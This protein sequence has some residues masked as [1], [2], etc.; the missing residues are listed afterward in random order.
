M[1]N[2]NDQLENPV[3]GKNE[4]AFDDQRG[5]TTPEGGNDSLAAD[6]E[7]EDSS[8]VLDEADLEENNISD[9]EADNIEWGPEGKKGGKQ[10]ITNAADTGSQNKGTDDDNRTGSN[11]MRTSDQPLK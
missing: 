7:E 5:K 3:E 9:D 2:K 10:D 4:Q 6:D 11:T 1:Q 8:P